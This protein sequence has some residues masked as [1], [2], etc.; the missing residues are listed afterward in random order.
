MKSGTLARIIV[1]IAIISILFTHTTTEFVSAD[2]DIFINR[3]STVTISVRLLQNGTYGDPVPNQNIEFYDQSYNTLLGHN[4]TNILGLAVFEWAVPLIHPL[5]PTVIN[6]TFRG[7]ESLFLLPTHQQIALNIISSTQMMIGD[8]EYTVAPLDSISIDV[9]LIDDSGL[10]IEAAAINILHANAT[11]VSMPTNSSGQVTFLLECNTTWLSLGENALDIVFFMDSVRYLEGSSKRISIEMNQIDSTIT[12]HTLDTDALLGEPM[13][14]SLHL[15][16]EEGILGNSPISIGL[17][18]KVLLDTSTDSAGNCTFNLPIDDNFQLGPN[19]LQLYY[20][21]TDR[22]SAYQIPIPIIV[23]S[24][25][26]LGI[27]FPESIFCELKVTFQITAT[28]SFGR[29]IRNFAL[30]I[31]DLSTGASTL[32]VFPQNETTSL[33]PMHIGGPPGSHAIQ[34]E[35]EPTLCLLN[36]SLVAQFEVWSQPQITLVSSNI[37]HFAFP[38]QS[39]LLII[40]VSDWQGNLSLQNLQILLNGAY[41]Q[42][43]TTDSNGVTSLS[44]KAP[45]NEVL[46]NITFLINQN[47]MLYQ[48]PATYEYMVMITQK[49]PVT[50]SMSSYEILSPL[51]QIV[52]RLSIQGMNG[53]FLCGT[54]IRFQWQGTSLNA[55]SLIGGRIEL[56][57]PIPQ[58]EGIHILVYYVE[59]TWSLN[60]TTGFLDILVTAL[61]ILSSQGMGIQFI[62]LS[63]L[64]SVALAVISLITKRSMIA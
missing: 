23:Y 30:N 62:A 4:R 27:Q 14:I 29:A 25:L 61:D 19:T 6:A 12:L 1:L 13:E 39:I 45:T 52:V 40:H 7:N 16:S 35:S 17:D 59:P 37:D 50:V 11:V 64:G 18:G 9:T 51:K 53:T 3:G 47:P 38:D 21:G 34:F 31:T 36:G 24:T 20:L 46:L 22:Y 28:D 63:L 54:M 55:T 56:I 10:P 60:A 33:V 57:L 49:M 48:A 2:D 58:N 5:G 43:V 8:D 41:T 15:S 32:G 26:H 44:I 42:I